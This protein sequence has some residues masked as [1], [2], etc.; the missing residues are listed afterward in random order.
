MVAGN[1]KGGR[2]ALA[3]ESDGRPEADAGNR[4]TAIP[5]RRATWA[6]AANESF[7]EPFIPSGQ[8]PVPNVTVQPF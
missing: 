2:H 4:R 7:T 1:A 5:R 3:F 8:W 6:G